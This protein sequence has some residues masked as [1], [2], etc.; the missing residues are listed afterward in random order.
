MP[1][2]QMTFVPGTKDSFINMID[3]SKAEQANYNM[4]TRQI[5]LFISNVVDMLITN[6]NRS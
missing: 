2:Q 1:V 4:D 6:A 5:S 3:T